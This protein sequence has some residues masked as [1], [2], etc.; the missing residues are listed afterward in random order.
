MMTN[1]LGEA[2]RAFDDAYEAWVLAW[3]KAYGALATPSDLTAKI[4]QGKAH[5]L[6]AASRALRK[7]RAASIRWI[8]AHAAHDFNDES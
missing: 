8:D 3:D 7:A 5:D 1:G 2:Q 6:L 4:E